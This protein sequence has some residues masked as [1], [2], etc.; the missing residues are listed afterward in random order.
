MALR[1]CLFSLSA[2]LLGAHFFRGGNFAMVALCLVSPFLF[3]FRKAWS[4]YLLQVLAYCAAAGWVGIAI[5]LIELRR[6]FG[7]PWR[8]AILILGAVALFTL[9]SGLLLNSR[10]IR[11]SY[12]K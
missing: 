8:L 3:F 11:Q 2:L 1:V 10:A 9:L 4:L 12:S 7:Q 6:Q 5:R